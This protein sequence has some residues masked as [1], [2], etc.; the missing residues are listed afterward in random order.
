MQEVKDGHVAQGQL[1]PVL[2]Q[3]AVLGEIQHGLQVAQGA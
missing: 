1:Q 3:A 2:P